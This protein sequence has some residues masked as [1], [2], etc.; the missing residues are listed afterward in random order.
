M[1]IY[2]HGNLNWKSISHKNLNSKLQSMQ[3]LLNRE[4]RENEALESRTIV[5]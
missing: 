1:Y 4:R 5:D 3:S 2:R